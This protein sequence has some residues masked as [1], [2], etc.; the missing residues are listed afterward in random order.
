MIAQSIECGVTLMRAH[1][2]VDEAVHFA[3]VDV[4]L[5]L[6]K[7]YRDIC[8]VQIAGE[9]HSIFLLPIVVNGF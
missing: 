5:R 3:C 2:E 4:G 6:R 1:V 9:A 8:H 7:L